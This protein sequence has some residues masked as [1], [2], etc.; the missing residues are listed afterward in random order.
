VPNALELTPPPLH[1]AAAGDNFRYTRKLR[2]AWIQA[3]S[4]VLH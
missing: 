1:A 4:I 2:Q 3:W